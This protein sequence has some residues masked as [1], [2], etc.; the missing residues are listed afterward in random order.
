MPRAPQIASPRGKG[1]V[2]RSITSADGI[3]GSAAAATAAV[4]PAA[5]VAAARVGN[6][7]TSF[8]S[9]GS[10]ATLASTGV[11]VGGSSS[12]S[13]SAAMWQQ[14]PRGPATLGPSPASAREKTADSAQQSSAQ[15][16]SVPPPNGPVMPMSVA[17]RLGSQ[18]PVPGI[19]LPVQPFGPSRELLSR[20]VQRKSDEDLS[21]RPMSDPGDDGPVPRGTQ[22]LICGGA[23]PP[24]ERARAARAFEPEAKPSQL[25][26][27]AAPVCQE[28]PAL[29]AMH[30]AVWMADIRRL[31]ELIRAGAEID[32]VDDRG[33]TPLTLAV[34]LLPRAPAEYEAVMRLLIDSEADPRIRSS[35][36]WSPL[37]EAVSRGDA[38][39]V[40]ILFDGAQRGL[41]RRW[42]TR[43]TA[44]LH[45]LEV[46]PDFE[47]RIRWEFDS[48]VVPLLG[49]IAPS[50]VVLVRK[51]GTSLRLDSTLA[52]WK[53][54]RL[55]K[56]RE[57]TTIFRGAAGQSGA[58]SLCMLNHTKRVAVDVTEGLDAEEKGAVINDL[59]SSDVMQW[60]MNV[61]DVDVSR[62]TGWLGQ[63]V[64][65]VEVNGWQTTR[66]DLKGSV[67]V[68]VR[69]KGC[70]RNTAT[71]E[72][73]FGQP[74]PA[75]ACLPELREEFR[76]SAPMPLKGLSRE[77][78]NVSE[79]SDATDGPDFF[80]QQIP[81]DDLLRS[82]E[83]A[84][85]A[86]LA[87]GS[88]T[89]GDDAAPVGSTASDPTDSYLGMPGKSEAHD[90]V[91]RTS[92]R[93]SAGVWLAHDFPVSLSKLLPV[94]EAMS[95]EHEAMFRL[96]EL[97]A[98]E[99][100]R[101]AIDNMR[102]HGYTSESNAFP[103]KLSVPINLAVR[104]L[105]HFES[106][107]V[108]SPKEAFPKEVF[109]VPA[110]YRWAP[111]REAQKT[112]G[113][114]RKRMLLAHFAL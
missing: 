68:V 100:L 96:K 53:R 33:S 102:R 98:S 42:E 39:L 108:I 30:M 82:L 5:A 71:Y 54:F 112:L 103:V 95:V 94:L 13:S 21:P 80:Q 43:L 109:Q 65:P 85:S 64:G 11:A 15:A 14:A 106:F 50:D 10:S 84:E 6:F 1:A 41:R 9:Y 16:F 23:L 12:S 8:C 79:W 87:K 92:R 46:L 60:D 105:V 47:C 36:G 55:S 81:E 49:R 78:S 7:P 69:K 52:S 61:D 90:K 83:S 29:C 86:P 67:G 104:G 18:A 22:P 74:L 99:G 70:R 91:G 40:R 3:R 89:A 48:P 34:E 57:L 58:P 26:S 72:E 45:S 56:R 44:V 51:R 20:Y 4:P 110:D 88:H 111:R 17:A 19:G 32:G 113:R 66:F 27:I 77:S 62:A 2:D 107:S 76:K 37:D 35:A 114:T 75:D 97:L 31:K 28:Q 101:N 38:Q 73:Y 93:V 25:S 24:A 63:A 59:V